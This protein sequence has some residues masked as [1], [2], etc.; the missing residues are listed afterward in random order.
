MSKPLYTK[1]EPYKTGWVRGFYDYAND[2]GARYRG[3]Y[4]TFGIMVEDR[5]LEET[6]SLFSEGYRDG[7]AARR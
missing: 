2:D 1:L 6:M 5:S 3:G 7:A 4:E